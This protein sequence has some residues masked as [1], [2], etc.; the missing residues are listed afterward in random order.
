MLGSIPV[1]VNPSMHPIPSEVPRCSSRSLKCLQTAPAPFG[2]RSP[3]S[4][5]R[6]YPAVLFSYL[7]SF[8]IHMSRAKLTASCYES[9]AMLYIQRPDMR[10]LSLYFTMASD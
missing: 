6:A 9:H 3:Q 7:T 10:M 1:E 4:P 2:W 8:I 5:S